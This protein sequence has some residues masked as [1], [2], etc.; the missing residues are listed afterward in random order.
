MAER[1]VNFAGMTSERVILRECVSSVQELNTRVSVVDKPVLA[2]PVGQEILGLFRDPEARKAVIADMGLLSSFRDSGLSIPSFLEAGPRAKLR[3]DPRRI[4][5][6]IVTT[7]GLAPGLH[8][9]IH[10]IVK[11][12]VH[13][14]SLNQDSGHVLG[15]YNGFKGLCH[16]AD[17]HVA[18]TPKITEEWLGHGGSKLGNIRYYYEEKK[19]EEGIARMVEVI[20]ANLRHNNIDILYIIGGDGSLK[21]AHQLAT[22]NPQ[23]SVVAVPKQWIMTFCGCGSRSGSILPLSKRR[24]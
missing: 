12:H 20:S 18:L 15:I 6:A 14:Y 4:R 9:V 11:R 1:I 16:L 3:H 7:G 5:A 23:R 10:S 24:E 17:Y 8:D 13:T 22:A 19:D 2:N 21:V